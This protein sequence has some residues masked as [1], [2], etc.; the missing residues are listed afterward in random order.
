MSARFNGYDH[1]LDRELEAV[2]MV[3][4]AFE[5]FETRVRY[6]IVGHSGESK[7][8]LFVNEKSP[9][10]DAKMR[11]ETIKASHILI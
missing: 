2:V 3:M 11:M 1:R 6:D 8:I 5:G 4:E 9:P 10:T 7:N